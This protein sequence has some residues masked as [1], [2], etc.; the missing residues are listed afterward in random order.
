MR[1]II[2]P[3]VVE[4][5]HDKGN[6]LPEMTEEEYDNLRRDIL[7]AATAFSK[8]KEEVVVFFRGTF[9][10]K[11][12]EFSVCRWEVFGLSP[13]QAIQ[14]IQDI[15]EQAVGVE[16]RPDTIHLDVLRQII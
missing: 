7:E 10:G 2:K 3:I 12:S 16:A 8:S 6:E 4:V 11:R 15:I 1:T 9:T 14:A 5:F 13:E